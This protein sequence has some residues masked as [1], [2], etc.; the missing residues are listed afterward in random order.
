MRMGK[1]REY[2][3]DEVSIPVFYVLEIYQ[4]TFRHE[5]PAVE[6]HT[7]EPLSPISVGDYLYEVCF[8]EPLAVH[9]GYLLQVAA[10]AACDFNTHKG[11]S[12]A[13]YE[14]LRKSDFPLQTGSFNYTAE[15]HGKRWTCYQHSRHFV[16][17]PAS[18]SWSFLDVCFLFVATYDWTVA[19]FG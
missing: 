11:S 2:G 8:P 13:H 14:G 16:T 10:K 9:R 7:A 6:I 19:R 18:F 1:P 4:D 15:I 3:D 12:N 5:K 17:I